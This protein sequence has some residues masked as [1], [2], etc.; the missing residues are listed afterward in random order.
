MNLKE[1][2]K[3]L[4]LSPGVYLMKDS[5]G[6]IIYVGKAKNLK[7]RVESYF[8]TSKADTEKVKKLKNSIHDFEFLLTDTEF[9]AFMLECQLIKEIKPFFNKKL[10]SP[11]AYSFIVFRMNDGIRRMEIA[12][13]IVENDGNLYFGPF[14]NKHTVEKALQGLKELFKIDC[15]NHSNSKT[16]CFNYSLGL[17]IGMCFSREALD[18]YHQIINQI[19]GLFQGR[20][21]GILEKIEKKMVTASEKFDFETAA[22]NRDYIDA[23]RVLLNREKVIDFT[24]GN[25]NIATIEALGDNNFKLFLIKRNKIL[26]SEIFKLEDLEQQYTMIKNQI[27]TYFN[28]DGPYENKKV[29]KDEI[30]EAQIIYSF[31]KGSGSSYTVIPENWLKTGDNSLLENTINQLLKQ[32]GA[33]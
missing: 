32:N 28:A 14:T 30:D 16:P 23:L 4:P 33:N 1:K 12:N 13:T 24:E 8:R 26:L 20:N 9:E 17:C 6:S 18:L 27:L 5:H 11:Q 10:K 19:I 7:R 3:N 2:V 31:L 21:T 22:R 15:C 29:S 25:R